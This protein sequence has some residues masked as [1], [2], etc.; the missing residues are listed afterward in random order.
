MALFDPNSR[1]D[2]RL[3]KIIEPGHAISKPVYNM[4]MGGVVLY[5]LVVNLI[6]CSI[7]SVADLYMTTN[8]II[9][10]IVYF[11]LCFGGCALSSKSESPIMSFIGYNMVCCP[12]GVVVS[13]LVAGY[14][15]LGSELVTQAF[16]ITSVIVACMVVA[17]MIFPQIFD[18]LGGTLLSILIALIVAE[19]VCLLF[20]MQQIITSWIAALLFSAYIGFDFHRSQQFEPCLDNAVDCALDIYMDIINLFIRILRILASTRRRD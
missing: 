20:G 10:L 14:G 15:G 2:E 12:M 4:V 13:A 16:F 5:G 8:P 9:F 6:L 18:K 11:A 17:A 19:L 1:R 7:P 3:N